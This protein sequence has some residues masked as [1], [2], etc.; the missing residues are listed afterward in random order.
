MD[1]ARVMLTAKE[2]SAAIQVHLGILQNVIDRMAGNSASAKTWCITL[3]S[4]LLVVA[5]DRQKPNIALIALIPSAVF[6]LLD[7]YY[8][9]LERGF[10]ETYNDFVS[11]VHLGT[12]SASDLYAVTPTGSRFRQWA[13][14]AASFSIWGFYSMVFG[15]VLVA[16]RY[17]L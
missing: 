7:A 16:R 12:A 6:C 1:D 2:S 3:V 9:G 17:L 13:C 4:A 10:R 11:K 14:S 15:L 8:L 5:A